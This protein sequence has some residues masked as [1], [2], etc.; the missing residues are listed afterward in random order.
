MVYSDISSSASIM[1][2]IITIDSSAISKNKHNLNLTGTFRSMN[3]QEIF[4]F[5]IVLCDGEFHQR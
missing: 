3:N 4:P 1:K 2:I 5:F